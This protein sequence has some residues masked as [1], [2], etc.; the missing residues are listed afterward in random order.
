MGLQ[1]LIENPPPIGDLPAWRKILIVCALGFA[2]FVG[3]MNVDIEFN[4]YG[5]APDHPVAES[6]QTYTVHVMHGYA[7]YVTREERDRKAFWNLA[8]TWAGSAFLIAFFLWITS[9]RRVA[10]RS[11]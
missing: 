1:D 6:G 10:A 5:G 2:F 3:F 4:I 7:R 11:R 9:R 8:I